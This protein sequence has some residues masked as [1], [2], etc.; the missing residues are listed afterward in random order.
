M[1]LANPEIYAN[2]NESAKAGQP[3]TT[4]QPPWPR[5]AWRA[6][7]E[8]QESRRQFPEQWLESTGQ[9]VLAS[10]RYGK[11]L[12]TVNRDRAAASGHSRLQWRLAEKS[13]PFAQATLDALP[14]H[15]AVLD[16]AG[17]IIAV[18]KSWRQFAGANYLAL[19]AQASLPGHEYAHATAQGIRAVMAGASTEFQLEYA[20]HTP[21][22]ARWFLVRVTGF[23]DGGHLVVSHENISERKQAEEA[24]RQSHHR[25]E[26]TLDQLRQTQAQLVQQE[27]LAAVGQLAA[28]IAHDFNNILTIVALQVQMALRS[29][30][31]A[32]PLQKRLETIAQQSRRAADLVQQI[33]DFGRRSVL[34]PRPLDLA[35]FLQEQVEL[36]RRTIPEHIHIALHPTT[37]ECVINADPTRIQQMLAN[38]VLNARDAMPQGGELHIG[39]RQHWPEAGAGALP[40]GMETGAW[41]EVT[42]RDTGEGIAPEVL[43]HIYEPFFTAKEHGKG[44]GLGLAQVY[45]IV[46]QHAGH[47]AVQSQPGAGATFTIYLPALASAPEV[48]QPPVQP[49][50]LPQGQGET[51]LVVEDN[52]SLRATL[53]DTLALLNYKTL[54]ASNGR[55]ALAV[56][57]AQGSEIALVL[58][59]LLMPEMGG[60]ALYHA[61]RQRGWTLPVVLLSGHPMEVEL[62]ALQAQGVAGWLLKPLETAQLAALLARAL[63]AA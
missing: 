4:P 56:L 25:L 48:M 6:Q 1:P 3:A 23:G 45:G 19:C 63:H 57:E 41:V 34:Q 32:P 46:K 18:N 51:I 40:P 27:R 35:S 59:D 31:V 24:L 22:E 21:T 36:F 17:E 20:C 42:V 55:Q 13:E 44:A 49:A 37:D 61:L 11:V 10:D 39:L 58:S 26:E 16:A 52:A 50:T 29:P 7:R 9:G 54:T 53:V 8:E 12:Y 15:I 30:D 43:P 38:L 33:L 62:Q 2:P 28:G 5:P 60:E 14:A 47:I